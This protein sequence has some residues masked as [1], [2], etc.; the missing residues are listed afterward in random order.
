MQYVNYEL[1][2]IVNIVIKK[3]TNIRDDLIM[4]THFILVFTIEDVT[5]AEFTFANVCQEEN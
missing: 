3:Y 1:E 5:F 2:N 4:I